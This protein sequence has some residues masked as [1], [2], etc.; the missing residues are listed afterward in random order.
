MNIWAVYS[1]KNTNFA[2]LDGFCII[3]NLFYCQF[4]FSATTA[5]FDHKSI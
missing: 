1:E 5:E 4:Y 3:G 2:Q